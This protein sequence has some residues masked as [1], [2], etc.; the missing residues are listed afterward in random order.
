M[1]YEITFIAMTTKGDVVGTRT[2]CITSSE[3]LDIKGKTASLLRLCVEYARLTGIK[4][5]FAEIIDIDERVAGA[6]REED[7]KA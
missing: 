5:S 1:K 3:R 2:F 4:C 7:T 6:R